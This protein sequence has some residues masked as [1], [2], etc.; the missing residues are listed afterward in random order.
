MKR[1][2]RGR[3]NVLYSLS[4][5]FPHLICGT[6]NGEWKIIYNFIFAT[7]VVC[8]V[9]NRLTVVSLWIKYPNYSRLSR[10]IHNPNISLTLKVSLI[11]EGII[12]CITEV[13]QNWLLTTVHSWTEA[14]ALFVTLCHL[15]TK[16]C[17]VSVLISQ[18]SFAIK[19]VGLCGSA[20]FKA[21]LLLCVFFILRLW[22]N[23]LKW[24]TIWCLF[25]VRGRLVELQVRIMAELLTGQCNDF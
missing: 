12:Q 18:S 1:K 4:L 2:R 13:R 25:V 3:V 20:C 7:F 5:S 9:I 24:H 10:I 14:K 19:N 17:H 11:A 6:F 8:K 23:F 21:G 15:H 16:L 22:R